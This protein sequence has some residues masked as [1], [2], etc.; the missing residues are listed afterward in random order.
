[1]I[2]INPYLNILIDILAIIAFLW[3]ILQ[4]FQ[5]K[6]KVSSVDMLTKFDF[7]ELNSLFEKLDS[8]IKQAKAQ[9]VT[10]KA[11]VFDYVEQ[12][13]NPIVARM[14]TRMAREEKKESEIE[15]KRGGILGLSRSG[16]T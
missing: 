7:N 14:R 15:P 13:L 2:D 8:D 10:T 9:A 1:M 11:E 5:M 6:R 16:T 3:T 4:H 12:Q